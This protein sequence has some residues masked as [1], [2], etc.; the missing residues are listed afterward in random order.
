MH[1]D[2]R[3]RQRSIAIGLGLAA[4]TAI[5]TAV[6]TALG[7]PAAAETASGFTKAAFGNTSEGKPVEVYT[8]TNDHGVVVRF[9]SFGGIITEVQTPD[10]AG[11]LGNVVLGLTSVQDYEKDTAYFGAL[12]GRY[13]NRIGAARFSLD[14]KEYKLA[15][16]NGPNSLHGGP[17]GFSKVVWNVEPGPASADGV[18][19]TLSYTS[20]AGE[21]GYPGKLDVSV[22]YTLTNDDALRIDYQASTDADTV[23][24]LT[25]HTYWNLGGN[26]AGSITDQQLQIAADRYTPIDAT[27][28][29]TGE[30]AA[31]AGTPFD[32][33]TPVPIGAR[34]R[35]P[36]PQMLTAHGYD[37]NL[38]LN[39]PSPEGPT[40]ALAP[41]ARAYDP[42]SGR[43]LE[44]LTTEPGMQFYTGNFLDGS[45][46]GSAGSAYRQTD[47]FALET[48]HFP[49]SPNKPAFPTT[50]L[51]PGQTFR[52]TTVFRFSTDSRT[53]P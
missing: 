53:A 2:R 45:V 23:V 47:G 52:S 40:P 14:D 1:P 16:N 29:P 3:R 8:M 42:E 28:I 11:R 26:G 21:E 10:R 46:A 39:K 4:M 25:N 31:V 15:A 20:Q 48:Q 41:A 19:A 43:I 30:L 9:L 27:L 50:E 18:R 5:G 7:A 17:K 6:G 51:K 12:V 13:A 35:S 24:N 49:D 22:T 32:F 33:R 34:I 38:V 36:S 44:V 37:H